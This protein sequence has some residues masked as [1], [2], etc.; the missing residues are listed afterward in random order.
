MMGRQ[1]GC[2]VQT[3]LHMWLVHQSV[4]RGRIRDA[5]A[6]QAPVTDPLILT[7]LEATTVAIMDIQGVATFDAVDA[8]MSQD[9]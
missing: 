2:L 1:R 6:E 5:C 4:F 9:G 7:S 3:L 8:L